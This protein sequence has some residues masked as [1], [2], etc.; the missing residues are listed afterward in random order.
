M[1]SVARVGLGALGIVADVT[2]RCVPAFELHCTEAPVV[3]EQMIEAWDDAV[4]ARRPLRVLVGAL[5][6]VGAHEGEPP[7][8]L[9]RSPAGVLRWTTG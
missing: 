4:A 3:L 8:G 5:D 7:G 9:D 1:L 2:L 6:R